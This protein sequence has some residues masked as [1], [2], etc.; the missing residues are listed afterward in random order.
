MSYESFLRIGAFSRASSLSVKALRA[1]HETGL[2]VP[3]AI[4]P[5]TGYRS[6]SVAQLTDA[7]IIRQLRELDMPL[8]AIRAVLD[9][10]D[11]AVT[12]KV[13]SEHG[14][15]LEERLAATQRAID[16]LYVALDSPAAHTPV[17]VR[18]EPSVTVLA[19]SGTVSEW[20]WLPFLDHARSSLMAAVADSDAVVEGAFGALY[21]TLLEDDAQDVVAY[22]PVRDASVL[23]TQSRATGVRVD[24]LP[25]V[26]VAVLV[27]VG[28]YDTI[29]DTYT[30]LGAWVGVN[31]DPAEQPVRESYLIGRHDHDDPASFRTEILWPVRTARDTA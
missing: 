22:M 7:T 15:A 31:A 2:L 29:S 19:C 14:S 23:T 18:S 28:A 1:Y 6:Y 25:A 26:D 10:R 12:T 30:K 20:E 9:A 8:D 21:P 16:Q 27:H 11:P 5:Q 13:L 4:D 17:H 3:A 24:V